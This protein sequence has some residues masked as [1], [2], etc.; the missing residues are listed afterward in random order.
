MSS[1]KEIAKVSYH[2]LRATKNVVVGVP[3]DI[4]MGMG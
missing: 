3:A 2:F 4:K 1:F